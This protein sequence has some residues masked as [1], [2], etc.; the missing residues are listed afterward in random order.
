MRIDMA[1]KR[2]KKHKVK[3]PGPEDQVFDV[4]IK[5]NPK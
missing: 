1:A 3:N 5:F 4:R 2:H